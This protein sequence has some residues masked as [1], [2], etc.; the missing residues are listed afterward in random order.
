MRHAQPRIAAA[1]NL[2]KRHR[3]RWCT[4]PADQKEAIRN[5]FR[6]PFC[7][8][9]I[10]PSVQSEALSHTDVLCKRGMQRLGRVEGDAQDAFVFPEWKHHGSREGWTRRL[11]CCVRI[12]A[13]AERLCLCSGVAVAAQQ[14][15]QLIA[16]PLSDSKT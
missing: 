4:N 7:L 11:I 8:R 12:G 1:A 3:R 6:N 10:N 13:V 9:L 2:L 14:Y 5:D 15:Y 16:L